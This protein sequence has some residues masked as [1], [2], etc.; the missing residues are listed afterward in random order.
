M[1]ITNLTTDDAALAEFGRRMAEA[2]L[3]RGMTQA[4]FAQAAG[5]S[6]RTIERLEDGGS[7][8]VA[9]L[10]R[11]LRALDRLEG[12][13]RLLPETPPNPIDLLERHG[14]TRQRARPDADDGRDAAAA[15]PWAWGDDR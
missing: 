11:C 9:N 15:A 5:V 4:Q 6:K 12:L 3:A 13:E 14:K 8:Q 7:I 2:R 1:K 10:I